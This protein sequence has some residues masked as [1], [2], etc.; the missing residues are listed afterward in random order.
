MKAN[1]STV[2]ALLL[3][4]AAGTRAEPPDKGERPLQPAGL[5]AIWKDF[6]QNDDAGSKKAWQ[7]MHAMIQSPQ[8]AVPF[9]KERV[10]PAPHPDRKRIDQCLADLDSKN[11]KTREKAMKELEGL[12]Q[13]AV[14]SI[15]RKLAE[16]GLSLEARKRTEA[17][18]LK[19]NRSVLSGDELR[20]IRAVEV[21]EGIG[22]PEALAVLKDLASGGEGAV[23][24]EQA[25]KALARLA[26]R[27]GGK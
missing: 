10:K 16:T 7:G 20:T 27:S 25:R 9:L 26:R 18:A 4:G 14:P 11:F 19:L 3:T 13:L 21:L 17:L 2:L 24:T 22:T 6:T 1:L 15:D 23:L 5:E 8:L 12:G